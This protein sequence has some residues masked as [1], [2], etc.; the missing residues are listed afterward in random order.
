MLDMLRHKFPM[1]TTFRLRGNELPGLE[2]ASCDLVISTLTIAHI[3]DPVAALKEWNRVLKPGGAIIITDYH[4]EALAK[5]AK[6]TFKHGD[7]HLSIKNYIHPVEEIKNIGRQLGLSS[8]RSEE[9]K[10]DETM[11]H[12]YEAQNAAK[13]FEQ[14]K[15]VPIIYGIILKKADG[16]A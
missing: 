16:P 13:L 4:P 11:R 1:A 8:I 10:V 9:N 15:G 3:E 6:R 14:W 12:Y 5:G 7:R 2:N